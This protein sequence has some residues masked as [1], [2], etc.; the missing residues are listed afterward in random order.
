[1]NSLVFCPECGTLVD[2]PTGTD[3]NV[4]CHCCN[5]LIPGTQFESLQ[6]VTTS[7]KDA[8]TS[9]PRQEAKENKD[10]LKDGATVFYF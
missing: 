4:E 9:K 7:T 2:Q 1:M 5:T 10:Y 8:F 3:D 6:V